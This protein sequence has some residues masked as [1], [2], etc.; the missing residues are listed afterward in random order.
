MAIACTL[1]RGETTGVAAWKFRISAARISQLR[2][3][4]KENWEQ[5]HGEEPSGKHS[6]G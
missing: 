4:F 6:R 2:A 5:F 3:W 1:A